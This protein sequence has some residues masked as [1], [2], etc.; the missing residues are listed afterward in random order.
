MY[1]EGIHCPAPPQ[2]PNARSENNEWN[3]YGTEVSYTCDP[4]YK[5]Q[6]QLTCGADSTYYGA[7]PN[8]TS[9]WGERL[10]A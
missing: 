3:D 8:C 4:G 2:F 5:G 9:K 10:T 1:V 6:G 7:L